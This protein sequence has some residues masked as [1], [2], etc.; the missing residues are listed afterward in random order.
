MKYKSQA[1]SR[2]ISKSKYK[3]GNMWKATKSHGKP[4]VIIDVI[5]KNPRS[6]IIW[7]LKWH[8]TIKG[9]IRSS[10]RKDSQ[11]VMQCWSIH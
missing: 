9:V 2:K 11:K 8:K 1:I 5:R 3:D 6:Q 4:I 10:N 7:K